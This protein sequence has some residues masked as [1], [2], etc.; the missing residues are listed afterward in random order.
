MQY[1]DF[2]IVLGRFHLEFNW[3]GQKLGVYL[4]I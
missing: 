3:R 4:Q 1:A 2:C